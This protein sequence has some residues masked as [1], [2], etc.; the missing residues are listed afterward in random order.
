M[1][2][3][4]SQLDHVGCDTPN[5]KHDHS[6]LYMK[7][8]CHERAGVDVVYHKATGTLKLACAVCHRPVVEITVAA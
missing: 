4:R 5:C 2:L 7:S 1:S 3:T 8:R 6:M